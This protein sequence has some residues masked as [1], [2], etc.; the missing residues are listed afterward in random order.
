M[1][2]HLQ[3]YSKTMDWLILTASRKAGEASLYFER[4]FLKNSVLGLLFKNSFFYRFYFNTA[5]PLRSPKA[6]GWIL[7]LGE[8]SQ[9]AVV[10][11]W[12]TEDVSGHSETLGVGIIKTTL[13]RLIMTP[14]MF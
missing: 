11:D 14:K 5:K 3:F 10:L 2:Y 6:T 13:V 8:T 9:L 12:A 4:C 7:K 1:H